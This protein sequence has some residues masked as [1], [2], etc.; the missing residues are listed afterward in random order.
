MTRVPASEKL[1]LGAA[2]YPLSAWN[3]SYSGQFVWYTIEFHKRTYV[4]NAG[5]KDHR[6]KEAAKPVI[7]V[8]DKPNW[9]TS[10]LTSLSVPACCDRQNNNRLRWIKGS[11]PWQ[12]RHRR[13]I[14]W[15]DSR[16]TERLTAYDWRP[17]KEGLLLRN[18]FLTPCFQKQ[19]R[20]HDG[21]KNGEKPY[22]QSFSPFTYI[23]S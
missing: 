18:T 13:S 12:K 21:G 10:A 3:K 15:L 14:D 20:F 9:P 5:L 17:L 1:I 22:I 4:E 6:N 2:P 19:Q 16:K 23:D 11:V 7:L 8:S